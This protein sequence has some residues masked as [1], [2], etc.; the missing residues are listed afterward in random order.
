MA[1]TN[2]EGSLNTPFDRQPEPLQC[3]L[4]SNMSQ[5]NQAIYIR[6]RPFFQAHFD[7]CRSV[8]IGTDLGPSSSRHIHNRWMTRGS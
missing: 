6:T 4:W 3:L 7:W 1:T 5:T 8:F 2:H